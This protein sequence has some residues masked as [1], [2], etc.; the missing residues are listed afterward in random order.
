MKKII[1]IDWE[2]Y[3]GMVIDLAKIIKWKGIKQIY[4]IGRGGMI[5][6]VMLSHLHNDLPVE[7]YTPGQELWR[8]PW[9]YQKENTLVVDDISDTGKTFVKASKM[10]P[11]ATK[12]ASLH[13]KR[14][15]IFQPDYWVESVELDTWIKYPYERKPY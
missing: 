2:D 11:K 15:S 9:G 1:S 10:F 8:M 12:Y 3:N 13:F 7:L 6:A 14:S 5:L 4:G